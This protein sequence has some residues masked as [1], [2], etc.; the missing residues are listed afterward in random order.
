MP[1]FWSQNEKIV[2]AIDMNDFARPMFS[3]TL[4]CSALDA[5]LCSSQLPAVIPCERLTQ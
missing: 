3:S 1:Y 5:D 4:S 2:S